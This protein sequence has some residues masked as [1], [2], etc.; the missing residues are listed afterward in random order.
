VIAQSDGSESDDG[1]RRAL[2]DVT[3]AGSWDVPAGRQLLRAIRD[4]AV[5]N[6]AHVA[7]ATGVRCDRDLVGDVVTAAWLVLHRHT[8]QVLAADRPW[9]YLMHAAQQDVMSEALADRAVTS[10]TAASGRH[11]QQVWTTMVA[12]VGTAAGQVAA[13]L[14]H[15]HRDEGLRE[16]GDRHGLPRRR[17]E[18]ALVERPHERSELRERDSWYA[19]FI[20]V[21]AGHGADASRTTAAV[22]HLADLFSVTSSKQWETAARQDPVLAR[23]GLSP[24][25][26]SALVALVAGSRRDRESGRPGGLLGTIRAAEKHGGPVTLSSADRN[27]VHTYVNG[28]GPARRDK[29]GEHRLP[30]PGQAVRAEMT[31]AGVTQEVVATRLGLRRQNVSTRLAGVVGWTPDELAT[32][33]DLLDVP[34]ARL[35]DLRRAAGR[36]PQPHTILATRA[37]VPAR[38]GD[39]LAALHR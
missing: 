37:D 9:A 13:A 28:T 17:G 34:I 16:G 15:G 25:Q 33:A 20:D 12:R 36:S 19:T 4:R 3:D 29:H 39:R 11:R 32:V 35:L 14:G 7:A 22:D 24:D 38:S 21:L 1:L 27:R 31:R 18:A 30:V 23:L 6:A 26:A 2:R 10:R 5:R 8:E